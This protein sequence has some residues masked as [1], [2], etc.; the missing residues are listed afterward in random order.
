MLEKYPLCKWPI[1]FLQEQLGDLGTGDFVVIGCDTGVGKSTLSRMIARSARESDCPT[2]LYSLENKPG[3]FALEE[4]K[5]AFQY[6]T[7]EYMTERQFAYARTKNPQEYQRYA[8]KAA[9]TATKRTK[10]GIPLLKV[11]EQP[12]RGGFNAKSLIQQLQGDV[13]QGYKLFIIDHLDVID[14]HN[15]LQACYEVMAEL[16]AFVCEQEVGVVAFSQLSKNNNSP[17][18]PC[19]DDIWGAKAKS[20]KATHVITLAK[21]LYGYYQPPFSHPTAQ[22]TYINLAKCRDDKT[23]CAVCFFDGDKYLDNFIPVT[24]TDNGRYVDGK[25]RDWFIRWQAKQKEE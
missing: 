22:A 20:F 24:F 14:I 1:K 16:W 15:A 17:L 21:H 5:L 7:G 25:N 2:S 6:E 18:C 23:A 10:E 3:T 9:R 13:A 4:I 12:V 11:T 19:Y 8:Q